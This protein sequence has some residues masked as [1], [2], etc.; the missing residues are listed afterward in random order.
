VVLPAGEWTLVAYIHDSVG[1][2]TRYEV[3]DIIVRAAQVNEDETENE[4][5][6]LCFVRNQTYTLLARLQ[7]GFSRSLLFFIAA[8]AP[9]RVLS[10]RC[11]VI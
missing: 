8:H 3:G 6:E 9:P 7:V 10:L 2:V 4:H 1:G 5:A 11:M